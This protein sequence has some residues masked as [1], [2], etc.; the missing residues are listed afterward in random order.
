MV[1][2][3]RW[4]QW[5]IASSHL[6]CNGWTTPGWR[7]S[8]SRDRG[9]GRLWACH[10]R[11]SCSNENYYARRTALRRRL[12]PVCRST[13]Q[14]HLFPSR[15]GRGSFVHRP[16]GWTIAL[17]S[18][19]S[20]TLSVAVGSDAGT[21]GDHVALIAQLLFGLPL[22]TSSRGLLSHWHLSV[23]LSRRRCSISTPAGIVAVISS[24]L[25]RRWIDRGHIAGARG[26]TTPIPDPFRCGV[27][28]I[29]DGVAFGAAVAVSGRPSR[30][31]A[32][33][34]SL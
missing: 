13:N 26:R 15:S 17:G 3:V 25:E 2:S 23:V 22:W 30:D 20:R 12:Q 1:L 18:R 19:R 16:S 14:Q 27:R 8:R 9:P 5:P 24:W 4:P 7:S 21:G 10:P 28:A 33:M 34:S 29:R 6:S 31:L 11:C 32:A